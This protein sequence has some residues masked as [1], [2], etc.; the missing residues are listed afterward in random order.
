MGIANFYRGDT[1]EWAVSFTDAQNVAIPL[2]GKKLYFTMKLDKALSDAA[3]GVFQKI[4]TFPNDAESTAGRGILQL[5]ATETETLAIETYFYDFQLVDTTV[6][7]VKVT[8][9]GEGKVKVLEDVT[10]TTT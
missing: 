10:R 3:T 9:V 6:N 5:T 8:T 7:P 4:H 1:K 2:Y